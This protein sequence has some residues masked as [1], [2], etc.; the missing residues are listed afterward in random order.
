MQNCES[1]PEDVPS[2][3]AKCGARGTRPA[4]VVRRLAP[5]EGYRCAPSPANV[6]EP[7]S[8]SQVGAQGLTCQENASSH[9]G[10][11]VRKIGGA[12]VGAGKMHQGRVRSLRERFYD[13]TDGFV[14]VHL[15]QADNQWDS[16]K[17]FIVRLELREY[18]PFMRSA[19]GSVADA[20]H[21]HHDDRARRRPRPGPRC[22]S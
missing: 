10:K 18:I 12:I 19:A 17:R 9:A 5:D 14:T 4:R 6:N 16:R 8:T 22:L 3:Y 13:G 2:Q 21:N 20:L 11:I 15:A 1:K 7:V